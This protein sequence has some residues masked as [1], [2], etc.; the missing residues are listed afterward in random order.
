MDADAVDLPEELKA[1]GAEPDTQ[2]IPSELAA[3]GVELEP[4]APEPLTPEEMLKQSQERRAEWE[5]KKTLTERLAEAIPQSVTAGLEAYGRATLPYIYGKTE[6]LLGVSQA[7]QER[8]A[9]EYLGAQLAGTLAGF[10]TSIALT[11][12]VAGAAKLAGAKAAAAAAASGAS[13]LSQIA[14]AAKAAAT[15]SPTAAEALAGPLAVAGR[16]GAATR[17][18]LTAAAPN[19]AEFG[20]AASLAP[21]ALKTASNLGTAAYKTA[22]GGAGALAEGAA[23]GTALELDESRLKNREMSGEAILHTALLSG[24]IGGLAEGFPAGAAFIGTTTAGKKLA[25]KLGSTAAGRVIKKFGATRSEVE[26]AKRQIGEERFFSVLNDAERFG[27]VK[28]TMSTARSGELAENMIE[29]SGKAIESFVNE[30][31][32]RIA[33][34]SSLAPKTSDVVETISDKVVAPL[35]DN[36]ETQAAASSIADRLRLIQEKY[37]ERVPLGELHRLRSDISKTIYSLRGTQDPLRSVEA[38]ALRQMRSLL[39]EQISSGLERVGID[40]KA[41]KVAQRQYEVASRIES[42][43][44]KAATRAAAKGAGD[45]T[46]WASAA[47]GLG[48]YLLHGLPGA[49]AAGIGAK[50]AIKGGQML[51]DWAP[52]ALQRALEAGAPPAMIRHLQEFANLRAA[53]LTAEARAGTQA[54]VAEVAA[55]MLDANSL[56][57]AKYYEVVDSLTGAE[58]SMLADP[59]LSH[60]RYEPYRNAISSAKNKL[61][62][63]I[64]GELTPTQAGELLQSVEE[65]LTPLSSLGPKRTWLE[66]PGVTVVRQMRNKVRDALSSSAAWGPEYHMGAID[67]T[68]ASAQALVDPERVAA[69][70]SLE[71]ITQR[72]QSRSASKA[73]TLMGVSRKTVTQYAKTKDRELRKEVNKMLNRPYED[74]SPSG[75]YEIHNGRPVIEISGATYG[76]PLGEEE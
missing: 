8:R 73:D 10:G 44:D 57:K 31:D 41:W 54:T 34:S 46:N 71:E 23:L 64:K 4:T 43:A 6:E 76:E 30:A 16:I 7:E 59:A 24:G 67:R 27:L 11:G 42:L 70:K 62:G 65:S 26:T 63:A 25:S 9:E 13:K 2:G 29:D 72:L 3:L 28:P 58:Q 53:Q 37:G 68:I 19:L 20:A 14:A 38:S 51:L 75:R 48:G 39:T 21:N 35:A 32:A 45:W 17:A 33:A 36:I 50:G 49:T 69:L 40:P 12:G 18:G 61:V 22:I 74:Y 5:A 1:L 55:P 52:G 60:S 15:V 56:A 47:T 66:Q